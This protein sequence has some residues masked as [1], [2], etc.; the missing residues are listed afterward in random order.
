MLVECPECGKEVSNKAE[1]C[2][3]CG[4]PVGYPNFYANVSSIGLDIYWLMSDYMEKYSKSDTLLS[5]SGTYPILFGGRYRYQ[6]SY[7]QTKEEALE[8]KDSAIA[9]MRKLPEKSEEY[10]KLFL[11]ARH[12]DA[13]VGT[14]NGPHPGNS[15]MEG[16]PELQEKCISN[17]E[18]VIDQYEGLIEKCNTSDDKD[19]FQ[20]RIDTIQEEIDKVQEMSYKNNT[21]NNEKESTYNN[22]RDKKD[23]WFDKFF[24][25]THK[26]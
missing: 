15:D 1:S 3:D 8:I 5:P 16:R 25:L 6:D 18:A 7:E 24:F 21:D 10:R 12:M 14:I 26:L 9:R 17:L 13:I 2:P 20:K 19:F 23:G 11:L 22:S 4:S